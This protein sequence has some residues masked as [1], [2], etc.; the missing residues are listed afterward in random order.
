MMVMASIGNIFFIPFAFRSD[1][2]FIF[3]NW[4]L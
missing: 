3:L 1:G 2:L 4:L